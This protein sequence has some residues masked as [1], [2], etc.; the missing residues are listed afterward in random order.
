MRQVVWTLALAV[1]AVSPAL[2][3]DPVKVEAK[4]Y[5]VVAE[6]DRVRVLKVTV[7]AGEKTVMHEHPDNFVVL[8]TDASIRFTTADG[9][10]VAAEGRKAG[11]VMVE[12]AGKHS[13]EN[14]GAA[15]LQAVIVEV[16]PGVTRAAVA[17]AV[18]PP[19]MATVK[20]TTIA[21]GTH[22]EAVRFEVQPGFEEPAGTKHEY[23]AVVVPMSGGG[24]SLT[25]DG[26]TVTME[27]GGVYL[28][29]RGAAHSVK[30]TAAAESIV[31]YVK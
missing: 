30:S 18:P 11:E 22:G 6:N 13:G 12:A 7:G 8:L 14:V 5:T 31:V 24:T 16:K 23:D 21:S 19:A 1:V 2:A 4:R 27:K 25:L 26:K 20:R 15:P 17:G 28:I 10:T 9:R 29:P 3:Q